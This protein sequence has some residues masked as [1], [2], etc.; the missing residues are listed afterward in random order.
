MASNEKSQPAMT[1]E[2]LEDMS[3]KLVQLLMQQQQQQQSSPS[4]NKS[5][6]Q[7]PDEVTLDTKLDYYSIPEVY[8]NYAFLK[9]TY[10]DQEMIGVGAVEFV[11]SKRGNYIQVIISYVAPYSSKKYTICHNT[12]QI[13]QFSGQVRIRD[14]PVIPLF[15]MSVIDT[16]NARGKVFESVTG[17]PTFKHVNGMMYVPTM[18]GMSRMPLNSRVVVDS[19]GYNKWCNANRWHDNEVLNQIPEDMFMSC[20]P[21]VPVY[22]LEYKAWGE[23]PVDQI[24]EIVFDETAFDRTVLRD[25]YKQRIKSLVSNFCTTHCTDFIAGREKGLNFLLSGPPGVGKTLSSMG[26]A[27]L[28]HKPLYIVGSGDLGTT[29]DVIDRKMKHIFDMVQHWS[30]IVLIDE[31]D[32]FMSKRDDTDLNRNACASV[33]LRHIEQYTGILFLTTNR[34]ASIDPA[35]DSRIHIRLRYDNLDFAGR[36]QVWAE[37]FR[38]YKIASVDPKEMAVYEINNREIANIVQLAFIDVAGDPTKVSS[39]LIHS[40]VHLRQNYEIKTDV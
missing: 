35:I 27:E 20:L 26:I 8:N 18:E 23:V 30:G 11:E 3:M 38:R 39:E 16:F 7:I 33:F 28:T 31:A 22:S 29:P 14:L 15:D 2:A 32:V 24:S 1:T 36:T 5:N 25:D 13:P 12:N 37:S 40:Y 9:T 17:G 6:Y 10:C 19:Q 21:T 4:S 34:N